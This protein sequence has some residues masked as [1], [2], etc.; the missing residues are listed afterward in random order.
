MKGFL[1]ELQKN[2]NPPS[3][4]NACS[5]AWRISDGPYVNTGLAR[6]NVVI[7]FKLTSDRV[8][9]IAPWSFS[10]RGQKGT[11]IGSG[12]HTLH[13]TLYEANLKSDC[14]PKSKKVIGDGFD[15][16][17]SNYINDR[18]AVFQW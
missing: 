3:V 7:F 18:H 9:E 16:S 4:I 10:L 11:E 14:S 15:T 13:L 6:G 17:Q 5:K 8:I 1:Q 2:L 12:L